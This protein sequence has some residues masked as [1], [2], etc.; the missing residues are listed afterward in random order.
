[1]IYKTENKLYP[2]RFKFE[3]SEKENS[4]GYFKSRRYLELKIAGGIVDT[5]TNIS[6]I[7]SVP[8]YIGK[9]AVYTYLCFIVLHMKESKGLTVLYCMA[10]N[11][12][13]GKF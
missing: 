11:F 6:Q 13:S 9:A 5:E 8:P 1:M 7:L 4:R 3:V 10:Q 12:D 2:P